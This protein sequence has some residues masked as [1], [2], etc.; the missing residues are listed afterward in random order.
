MESLTLYEI[1]WSYGVETI[2]YW[3]FFSIK[4]NKIKIENSIGIWGCSWCCWKAFNKLD[5]IELISQLLGLRCGRYCFWVDFVARNS[6][7]LQKN[8]FGRK[9]QLSLQCIHTWANGIGY[10]SLLARTYGSL[11]IRSSNIIIFQCIGEN[12]HNFKNKF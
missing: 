6:K 8:W 9:N 4:L 2:D 10:I 5:L 11:R 7:K 12:K 1:F 3:T